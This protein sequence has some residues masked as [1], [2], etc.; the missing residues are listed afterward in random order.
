[1]QTDT[2]HNAS[3][4][5]VS[6]DTVFFF[7]LFRPTFYYFLLV[8]VVIHDCCR[9]CYK[10]LIVLW[11]GAKFDTAT[12]QA[13]RWS[14]TPCLEHPAGGDNDISVSFDFLTTSRN[15]LTLQKITSFELIICQTASLFKLV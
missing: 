15:Q 13:L 5:S 2:K 7:I 10:N 12:T 3:T 1:M 11:Y 4:G 6:Y 14:L 8:N 9:K